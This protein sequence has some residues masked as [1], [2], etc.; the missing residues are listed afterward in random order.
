MRFMLRGAALGFLE[1]FFL[2]NEKRNS[3]QFELIKRFR[4]ELQRAINFS[5]HFAR[6]T[7]NHVS[8]GGSLLLIK[9]ENYLLVLH[10]ASQYLDDRVKQ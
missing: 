2:H 5:D 6:E 7:I 4:L 1:G 9:T 8:N 10:N 3:I